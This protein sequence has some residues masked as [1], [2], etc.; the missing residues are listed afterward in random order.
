MVGRNRLEYHLTMVGTEILNRTMR[1]RFL[2]TPHRLVILPPCMC[3]P[4]D[5]CKAATTDFGYRCA[6]CTP[7]CR[8]HQVTQLGK[9]HGFEALI[10]P[11][12]LG[13]FAN[14]KDTP[15][16]AKVG[17]V[18]IS[19]P[20]TNPTGGW[21]TRSIQVPAQGVLLDFCGCPWHWAL[22]G[23]IITD[24]NLQQLLKIV[25]TSE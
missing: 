3:N 14:K 19:C 8:V 1:E 22:D 5:K 12:D 2:D 4:E 23:A 16:S 15:L 11:D 10:M 18:G 24:V 20:L 13:V 21:R 17:I 25:G 7:G 6:A 9:K